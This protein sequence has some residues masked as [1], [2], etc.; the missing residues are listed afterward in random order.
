MAASSIALTRYYS[1]LR[2]FTCSSMQS[3]DELNH[4]EH[5]GYEGHEDHL[6]SS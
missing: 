5:E 3:C 1:R 2:L 6:M 4:E